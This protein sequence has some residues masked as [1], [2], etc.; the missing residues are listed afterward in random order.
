MD[1]SNLAPNI[2]QASPIANRMGDLL[3]QSEGLSRNPS[4]ETDTQNLYE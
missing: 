1:L 2:G 3:W 4:R